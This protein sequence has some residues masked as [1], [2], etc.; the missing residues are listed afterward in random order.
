MA[1]DKKMTQ[2]E[3]NK[4]I[5]S[6]QVS[7]EE[8]TGPALRV[9][10]YAPTTNKTVTKVNS[11]TSNMVSSP[12]VSS[13][14][15][16]TMPTLNTV[17]QAN[18]NY[19][20]KLSIFNK[21]SEAY[22]KKRIDEL[23]K[24][25][26]DLTRKLDKQ[27]FRNNIT[28]GRVTNKKTIQQR[29]KEYEKFEPKLK[30]LTQEEY[31]AKEGARN[32]LVLAAYQKAVA[33]T[34]AHDVNLFD[35]IVYPWIGGGLNIGSTITDETRYVD[36]N[37]N[38]MFLPSENDLMYQKVRDSYGNGFWGDVGRFYADTSQELGKQECVN[39]CYS[40]CILFQFLNILTAT[41]C[42]H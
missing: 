26:I 23:N 35:K 34:D 17:R 21:A 38:E 4:Y 18:E 15:T 29:E 16:V 6:K 8:Y 13:K 27:D 37:G 11:N 5:K 3:I 14:Q 20:D 30:E 1:K 40:T 41:E 10:S 25:N 33:D 12:T 22:D 39:S 42:L 2:S 19:K 9:N 28:D 31:N 32:D 24:N 7:S 36:E